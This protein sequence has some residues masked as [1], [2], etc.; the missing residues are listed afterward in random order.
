M[1]KAGAGSESTSRLDIYG[2]G[3]IANGVI[4]RTLCFPG[5]Q[6]AEVSLS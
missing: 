5:S 3:G 2:G 1:G 4:V 6:P